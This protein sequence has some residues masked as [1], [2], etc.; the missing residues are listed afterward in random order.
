MLYE[1]GDGGMLLIYVQCGNHGTDGMFADGRTLL[2]DRTLFDVTQI[3]KASTRG[4][5]SYD[6]C[7]RD[8][9]VAVLER[10]TKCYQV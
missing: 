10:T 4:V 6:I 9:K 2:F 8:S 7:M 5:K 3:G 1:L